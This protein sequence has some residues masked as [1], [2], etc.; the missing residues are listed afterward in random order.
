MENQDNDRKV[1]SLP[2]VFSL[3]PLTLPLSPQG[4]KEIREG[5]F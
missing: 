4:E 5:T 1:N 3:S 2:E